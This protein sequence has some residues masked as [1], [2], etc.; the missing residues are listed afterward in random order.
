VQGQ[1]VGLGDRR[2]ERDEANRR[3]VGRRRGWKRIVGDN[4]AAETMGDARDLAADSAGADQP[5][6]LP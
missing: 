5:K 1:N 6:V 2:V 4:G 3:A